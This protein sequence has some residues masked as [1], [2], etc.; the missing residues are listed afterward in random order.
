MPDSWAGKMG[1]VYFEAAPGCLASRPPRHLLRSKVA[2]AAV[3]VIDCKKL[4]S[5]MPP[6]PV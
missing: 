5:Y 2:A 3:T 6:E 4:V 1:V